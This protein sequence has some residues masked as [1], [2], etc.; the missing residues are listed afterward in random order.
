MKTV[1]NDRRQK[2]SKQVEQPYVDPDEEGFDDGQDDYNRDNNNRDNRN[3]QVVYSDDENA[4]SYDGNPEDNQDN[5]EPETKESLEAAMVQ[6]IEEFSDF[7]SAIT[8]D[9]EEQ[10]GEYM[11]GLKAK[12]KPLP[13]PI[14]KDS[15]FK[16]NFTKGLLMTV[17]D[18]DRLV[19]YYVV[20]LLPMKPWISARKEQFFLKANIFPGAPEEDVQFFRDLWGIDGTMDDREK[21]TIWEYWD[22]LY[23]IAE[24]WKALTG[25]EPTPEDDLDIPDIDYKQAAREAGI[26]D[27]EN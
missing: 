17:F 21:N 27:P 5:D 11:D 20:L 19:K 23:G 18:P 10:E 2:S 24:D 3:N 16:V 6:T 14:W 8:K 13:K 9:L 15:T 12:N 4:G 1:N 7:V 26:S 22:T 25:W